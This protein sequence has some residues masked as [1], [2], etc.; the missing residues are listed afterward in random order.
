[1]SRE[2]NDAVSEYTRV[3]MSDA[4]R[5][6]KLPETECP[7]IGFKLPRNR[8]PKRWDNVEDPTAHENAIKNGHPLARLPGDRRLEEVSLQEGSGT[9]TQ[10]EMSSSSPTGSTLFISGRRRHQKLVKKQ[11]WLLRG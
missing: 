4:S 5:L 1:M 2:A 8:C 9:S 7:T 3:K 6:P 11:D 10:L